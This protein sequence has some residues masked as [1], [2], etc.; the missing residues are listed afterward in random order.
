M[1]V[2]QPVF[3]LVGTQSD[4]HSVGTS[5]VTGGSSV[6]GVVVQLVPLQLG[7][8]SLL[9]VELADESL[10]EVVLDDEL[11]DELDDESLLGVVLTLTGA[12]DTDSDELSA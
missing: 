7:E 11:A 4:V 12:C 2:A 5:T 8:E 9:D 1:H 10:L 6:G 3:T